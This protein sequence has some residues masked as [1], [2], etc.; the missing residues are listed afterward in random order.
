MFDTAQLIEK[1][2]LPAKW[3]QSTI[4]PVV[5]SRAPSRLFVLTLIAAAIALATVAPVIVLASQV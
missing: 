3:N 5:V 4:S 2:H 1:N